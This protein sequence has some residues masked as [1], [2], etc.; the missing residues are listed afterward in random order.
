[1][2]VPNV[3]Q[4]SEPLLLDGLEELGLDVRIEIPDFVEKESAVPRY[5][6]EARLASTQRL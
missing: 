3:A 6:D 2:T 1:V 5:F 4:P